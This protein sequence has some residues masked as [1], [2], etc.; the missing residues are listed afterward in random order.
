MVFESGTARGTAQVK[1]AASDRTLVP[2]PV[3]DTDSLV[4]G[5]LFEQLV[6]TDTSSPRATQLQLDPWIVRATQMQLGPA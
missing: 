1:P 5:L 6:H 2:G 3:T 4:T